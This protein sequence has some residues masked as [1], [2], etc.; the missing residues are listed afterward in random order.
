[1]LPLPGAYDL[2]VFWRAGDKKSNWPVVQDGDKNVLDRIFLGFVV[3]P[4]AADTT[5]ATMAGARFGE[6][7]RL[8]SYHYDE[9]MPG[10]PWNVTL[11][12]E[13]LER[14]VKDYTVF[15][16][17]LDDEGQ[18]AVSHDGMPLEDRFPTSAW[19]PGMV[20]PDKHTLAL[21]AGLPPVRLPTEAEWERAARGNDRRPFPWGEE[22]SPGV[23][24][25]LES[26]RRDTA[27]AASLVF[28][29]TENFAV[30]S[31]YCQMFGGWPSSGYFLTGLPDDLRQMYQQA[32]SVGAR[33][34]SNSWG[35]ALAGEYTT[36]SANTDD[37]VWDNPDMAITF[38][39]GNEG[40]DRAI[41]LAP[42]LGPR[43]VVLGLGIRR[44]GVL[45]G[46]IRV[47]GL[48]GE[49]VGYRVVR[50]GIFRR[51][52]GR[53]DNNFGTVGAQQ[54]LL[55]DGLL[56]GHH[57]DQLV[58]AQ[59]RRHRQSHPGVPRRRFDDRA[60][61]LEQALALGPQHLSCYQLTY[62]EGTPFGF[63]KARGELAELPEETQAEQ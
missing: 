40:V 29:A 60:A 45:V 62:H 2:Q 21:P 44:V 6:T 28:Q 34:H 49:P 39:A 19:R 22:F 56:V 54:V 61:G 50:A 18:I 52:I 9:P 5:E 4:P 38:S 48:F 63:R 10:E 32:Y 15:V 51:N 30:I 47:W 57:R 55:L 35:A 11:F 20:I 42:D 13:A 46:P 53:A 23:T 1:M 37:F 58:A 33:I 25:T 31:N 8:D 59:R 27:P 43:G 7:I 26:E 12:W 14:P 24:N 36:D 16:H 3:A 41:R 17:L